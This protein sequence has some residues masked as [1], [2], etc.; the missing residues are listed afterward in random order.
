MSRARD[1]NSDL[2]IARADFRRSDNRAAGLSKCSEPAR[3]GTDAAQNFRN[4]K[5]KSQVCNLGSRGGE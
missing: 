4:C 2:K 3:L 1:A 5:L